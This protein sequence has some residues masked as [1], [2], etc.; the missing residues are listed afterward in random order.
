MGFYVDVDLALRADELRNNQNRTCVAGPFREV[1]EARGL[2]SRVL[3]RHGPAGGNAE[4]RLYGSKKRLEAFL[5]DYAYD[6]NPVKSFKGQ[7]PK[8]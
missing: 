8:A 7:R 2:T 1:I 4:V 5:K 6:A 3:N